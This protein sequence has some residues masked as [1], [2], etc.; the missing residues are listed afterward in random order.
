MNDTTL[1]FITHNS[2]HLAEKICRD[3]TQLPTIFIDNASTDGTVAAIRPHADN[4]LLIESSQNNGYGK[5]A[6]LAFGRLT[7]SFCLLANPDVDIQRNEIERLINTTTLLPH[8][9]L[10]IAPNS[11][12]VVTEID[13]PAPEGLKSITHATGCALLFNLDN[14]RKL[15]GFDENIFLYYEEMDLS[16]RAKQAGMKMYY[17]E[18]IHFAHDSKQSSAPSRALDDLRNWHFQWS[19]LYYKRKHR[20]WKS[21]FSSLFEYLVL[22]WAKKLFSSPEKKRKTTVKVRATL[23]HILGRQAFNSDGTP[24]QPH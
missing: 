14:F 13:E 22:G 23:A 21:Y 5:A 24:Y 17:A 2:A 11:G 18:N 1:V 3:A 10:Y 19:S 15:G 4:N 6:N 16:L 20:L 7:C 8:N 9:W 12:H